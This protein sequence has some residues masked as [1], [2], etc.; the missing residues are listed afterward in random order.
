M[1]TDPGPRP[2]PS[3]DTAPRRGILALILA[4]SIW[5]LAPLYYKSMAF[6]PPLEML[7]HRTIWSRVVIGLWLAAQRRLGDISR[8]IRSGE[9]PVVLIGAMMISVNWYLFIRAIQGG[10]AVEASLGYYIF[11]IV[12]VLLGML[13]FGERL[14]R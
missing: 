4:C 1:T 14:S 2:N 13:V 3:P 10:N 11:P 5:G 12:A 8:L 9:W 7:G 6:V